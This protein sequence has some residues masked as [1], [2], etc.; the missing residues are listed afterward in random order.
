M[1]YVVALGL[2]LLL[3]ACGGPYR[4]N[5][6]NNPIQ[7]KEKITMTDIVLKNLNLVSLSSNKTES[8]RLN[9][10]LEMQNEKKKDIWTDIQIAFF[11]SNDTEIERSSWESFNWERRAV[12]TYS[13]SALNDKAVDYRVFIR[14]IR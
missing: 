6:V 7:K 14:K 9:V 2:S 11:D 3:F 13:K 10:V 8:G 1:K 4:V 12:K 5:T